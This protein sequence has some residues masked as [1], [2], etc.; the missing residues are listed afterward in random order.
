LESPKTKITTLDKL[1]IGTR[2]VVRSKL[3]WRF[4]AVAK[5]VD[6]KIVLT[7]CSPSGRT[8]R[9]GRDLDTRVTYEGSIPVLVTDHP[10]H[11]RENF[12]RYDA[13]W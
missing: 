7:V 11:W 3:D 5:T 8:Y 12:T 10:G 1:T 4:A 13:G 6:D 2:L 9:L